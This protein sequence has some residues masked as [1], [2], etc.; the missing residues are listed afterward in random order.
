VVTPE[1]AY[2]TRHG[3]PGEDP[4]ATRLKW[5]HYLN[6]FRKDDPARLIRLVLET[7]DFVCGVRDS[8]ELLAARD[9][10][11]LDLIVWVDNPRVPDDPTV[12]FT[13]ADADI[14]IRNDDTIPVYLERWR[15]LAACLGVLR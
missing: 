8:Q 7:S 5:Y 10:G 15:R 9:Q 3:P 4:E 11:L 12:T 2:A 6:E 1:E 14:I 13:R